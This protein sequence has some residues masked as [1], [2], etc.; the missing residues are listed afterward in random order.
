MGE[1]GVVHQILTQAKSAK[2][3]LAPELMRKTEGTRWRKPPS[4][5]VNPHSNPIYVVHQWVNEDPTKMQKVEK[6]N[7][8]LQYVP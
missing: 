6:P 2:M 4:T 3:E 8:C 5:K 7:C 1:N